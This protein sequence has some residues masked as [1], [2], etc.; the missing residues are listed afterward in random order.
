MVLVHQLQWQEISKQP[1]MVSL[2]QQQREILQE[3]QQKISKKMVSLHLP[4]QRWED[5]EWK[6]TLHSPQLWID[7]E[8]QRLK[9]NAAQQH[10]ERV[11]IKLAQW[12]REEG[13]RRWILMMLP[14]PLK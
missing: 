9:M 1:L 10:L 6:A 5:F 7:G 13:H 11:E 12:T 8:L 3:Q 2:Q 14:L 4:R